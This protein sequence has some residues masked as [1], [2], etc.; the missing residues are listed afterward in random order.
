MT[1]G[2]GVIE[3]LDKLASHGDVSGLLVGI[4]ASGG[5]LWTVLRA[6]LR[7]RAAVESQRI[8]SRDLAATLPQLTDGGEFSEG[9]AGA[10]RYLRVVRH[11]PVEP[12]TTVRSDDEPRRA[13]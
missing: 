5:G 13:A 12:P 1:G 6:Y 2:F 9:A 10:R 7:Y 4:L 3:V 8:R 11:R